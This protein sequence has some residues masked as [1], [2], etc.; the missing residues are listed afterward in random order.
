MT[1]AFAEGSKDLRYTANSLF[2]ADD[3][4]VGV[5]DFSSILIEL[6]AVKLVACEGN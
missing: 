2:W 4:V 1:F 5:Q 3:V 6:L